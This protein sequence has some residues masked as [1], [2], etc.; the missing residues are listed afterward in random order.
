MLTGPDNHVGDRDDKYLGECNNHA[1][2]LVVPPTDFARQRCVLLHISRAKVHRNTKVLFARRRVIRTD[3]LAR[4]FVTR[5]IHRAR[6]IA[7]SA[8]DLP[9]YYVANLHVMMIDMPLIC[10]D[11]NCS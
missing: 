2:L 11:T 4:P 7:H 10:Q 6:S 9:N 8:I 1:C 5:N 3:A